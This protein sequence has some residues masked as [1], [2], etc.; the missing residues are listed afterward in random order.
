MHGTIFKALDCYERK[1]E[2][3]N[4]VFLLL[5]VAF[6]SAVFLSMIR[7]F[8]MAILL[9]GIFS[10]LARPTYRRFER[11]FRGRRGLASMTTVLLIVMVILIPLSALLGI[12][13]SQAISVGHS[14]SPWI[15]KQ[16]KDPSG[17]SKELETIPFYDKI[18]AYQ[19]PI[20]RKAGQLVGTVSSYLINGLSSFTLGTVNFLFMLFLMLYSMYFFLMDGDRFLAKILYYLPLEAEDEGRLLEKFTSV[21]RATLKGT[22][23]IG[24]LQGGLA[25]VAFAVVGIQGAA[26]WGA[27]MVVLSIIPAVGTGLVWFPAAVV[28]V[29]GGHYAKGIGLALFCGLAVGSIDNVL[30]PALVG[31]DTQMHVLFIL[32]ST[33]GGIAL[34][35]FLGI[36]IGPIVAALFVTVWDIYGVVFR[37]VLPETP[38]ITTGSTDGKP[39]Q[40]ARTTE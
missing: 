6:I 27:I 7:H 40:D 1:N 19:E 21:T 4:K 34:F 24:L 2:S 38:P 39:I 9:A 23:V 28:L 33:L 8:L 3:M 20:L 10:G 36:I 35:G 29:F 32:F 18:R 11:W 37:D 22:A 12:V 15:E 5:L 16:I 30:R 25:G 31:R 17:L 14:V 26:F 13:T